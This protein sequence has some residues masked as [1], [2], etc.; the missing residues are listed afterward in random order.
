LS[1]SDLPEE[2]QA[3]TIDILI[4]EQ[5]IQESKKQNP[6]NPKIQKRGTEHPKTSDPLAQGLSPWP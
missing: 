2:Q 5:K 3:Q 4:F 1:I 6:K